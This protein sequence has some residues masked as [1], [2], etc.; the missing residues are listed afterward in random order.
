MPVNV[1][2]NYLTGILVSVSGVAKLFRMSLLSR[3][4]SLSIFSFR[5]RLGCLPWDFNTIISLGVAKSKAQS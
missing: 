1:K 3:I 5:F 4:I 2:S